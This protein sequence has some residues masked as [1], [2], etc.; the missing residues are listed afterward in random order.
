[1]STA[2]AHAGSR[3]WLVWTLVSAGLLLLAVAN[4][5][6]VWVAVMSQ[7]DCVAHSRTGGE[8]HQYRAAKS[9]C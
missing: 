7:P 9:A 8:N 1:M 6:L 2:P 5:H 3:R 4:A